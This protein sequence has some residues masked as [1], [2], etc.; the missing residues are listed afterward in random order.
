[1]EGAYDR[2]RAARNRMQVTQNAQD[3]AQTRTQGS[4]DERQE[5]HDRAQ[6]EL[7]ASGGTETPAEAR[8]RL[9]R[10]EARAARLAARELREVA[11]AARDEAHRARDD[12]A[13]EDPGRG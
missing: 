2:E 11:Q 5:G 4:I 10:E 7:D 3:T 13:P 1:V 9:I 6:R 12:A 8:A